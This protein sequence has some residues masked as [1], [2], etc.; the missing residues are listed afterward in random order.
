MTL[1]FCV[2]T[3]V[4]KLIFSFRILLKILHEK[5]YLDRRRITL[6]F[7]QMANFKNSFAAEKLWLILSIF[8]LFF[9]VQLCRRSSYLVYICWW[10]TSIMPSSSKGI[11]SSAPSRDTNEILLL[12]IPVPNERQLEPPKII[13][14]ETKW[15]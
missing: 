2:F 6:L 1:H 10:C 4:L 15:T 5:F 13:T 7:I 12:F 14:N 9:T 11:S 8:F 3:Q